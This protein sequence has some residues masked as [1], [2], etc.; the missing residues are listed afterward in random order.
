MNPKGKD[1]LQQYSKKFAKGRLLDESVTLVSDA[2]FDMAGQWETEFNT[3]ERTVNFHG[4][5]C[6]LANDVIFMDLIISKERK[7]KRFYEE[8]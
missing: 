2:H 4:C 8:E 6:D 5:R 7:I 3:K 1:L